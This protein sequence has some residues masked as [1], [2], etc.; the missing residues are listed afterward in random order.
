[1]KRN[2]RGQCKNI[3]WKYCFICQNKR[4]PPDNTTDESLQTLSDHLTQFYE[5]EELDLESESLLPV[6]KE[7]LIST[8]Y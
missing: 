5:L 8:F 2:N 4:I 7:D 6:Y 1:M 3:D